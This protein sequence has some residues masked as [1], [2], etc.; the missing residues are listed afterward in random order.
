M[1]VLLLSLLHHTN[2]VNLLGYCSDG[3]QRILVYKYMSNGSLEDHLFSM[4]LF[5]TVSIFHYMGPI[6]NVTHKMKRFESIFYNF[7][8]FWLR[9]ESRRAKAARMGHKNQDC[10][11]SSTR[12]GI[13]A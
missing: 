8:V 1:E 4:S 2:L 6:R 11:G 7:L 13:L 10:N 9:L 3:E 12:P 5:I